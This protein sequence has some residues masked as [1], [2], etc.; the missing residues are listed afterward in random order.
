[1]RFSDYWAHLSKG[2]VQ[3]MQGASVNR[4]GEAPRP[5]RS[6]I[7]RRGPCSCWEVDITIAPNKAA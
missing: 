2:A 6:A 3:R 5:A 1:M 7:G 4:T